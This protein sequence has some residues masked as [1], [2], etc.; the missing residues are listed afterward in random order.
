MLL[1]QQR[2]KR[3][4]VTLI[5]ADGTQVGIVQRL[6]DPMIVSRV[7]SPAEFK[8]L[9]VLLKI[10]QDPRLAR[11]FFRIRQGRGIQGLQLSAVLQ[12]QGDKFLVAL[13]VLKIGVQRLDLVGRGGGAGGRPGL[14]PAPHPFDL[15][16]R[17]EG[18]VERGIPPQV[19][20]LMRQLV[21]NYTRHFHIAAPQ[22]RARQR[23]TE[24][25]QGG[26]GGDPGDIHV[27]AVALQPG[28]EVLRT[29]LREVTA[30]RHA[31][32]HQETPAHGLE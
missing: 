10:T 32:R 29:L 31:T 8:R 9:V 26:V 3:R 15:H 12:Q 1:R 6:V 2:L 17:R 23:I 24:P 30:V 21:K 19:Q 28:G 27:I 7:S 13:F 18:F 14:Q 22:H 25:A 16:R 4:H 20:L 11:A 5:Q